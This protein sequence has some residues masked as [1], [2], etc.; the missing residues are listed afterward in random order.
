MPCSGPGNQPNQ[1]TRPPRP[2]ALGRAV[3]ALL[4]TA[5]LAGCGATP[6]SA[7]GTSSATQASPAGC[8][9]GAA[10]TPAFTLAV[11]QEPATGVATP[12]GKCWS[13]IAYTGITNIST[14]QPPSGV[15]GQFKAAWSAQNLYVLAWVQKWPLQADNGGPAYTN[16]TIEFYLG[17][18]NTKQT[19][20]G[21]NDCQV[22][23]VYTGRAASHDTCNTSRTFTPVA[24][25]VPNKGYYIDLIVPWNMLN[26]A[27]PAKGQQYSFSIA[28]DIPD[29]NG[30]RV[31]QM[32]W[33][34]GQNDDWQSTQNWGTITLA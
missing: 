15:S 5:L 29:G 21:P 11:A 7:G 22:S 23:V 25:V 16:D 14:G 18:D 10:G 31:A 26:V 19:S 9:K 24:Q 32:E 3:A 6:S 20:Y 28:W 8:A 33:A 4:G 17:G 13:S 34:G 1:G 12:T 2:R 27:K 30:N